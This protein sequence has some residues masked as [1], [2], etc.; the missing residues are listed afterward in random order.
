[1][2]IKELLSKCE[3]AYLDKDFKKLLGLCDEVLKSDPDNQTATSY[4]AISY[5]FL[6]HPERTVEMLEK[7]IQRHPNNY[8][9]KNNL[10]MAYY[11][12]GE[13]EKSLECC[14]EGLEIRDFDWLAENKIKAL[15]KLDRLDEAIEFYESS[16]D[17]IKICKL[18]V[19]AGRY[20][21]ALKYSRCDY[22]KCIDKIKQRDVDAVGEYYLSWIGMI[23]VVNSPDCT[24]RCDDERLKG[25]IEYNIRKLTGILRGKSIVFVHS[26]DT[27]KSELGSLDD[28]EFNAF[29]NRLIEIGYLEEPRKGYVKLAG[30]DGWKCAK[31]YLDE[32]KYAAPPWLVFPSYSAATIGWRMSFGEDYIMNHPHHSKEYAELF[33]M[34]EYWKFAIGERPLK[35][36][37]P[38]GWFWREDGKPKYPKVSKGIKVND[39]I[40]PDDEG[41]FFSDTFCFHSI[42]QSEEI[43]RYLYFE[44]YGSGDDDEDEKTWQSYRYSVLL[45]ASYLKVMQNEDLKQKLLETGDEPLVCVSD[46]G[47][48]LFARALM[49]VRDEIRRVCK[50][51]SL[52][53]WE[54][55][56]YLKYKP[57]W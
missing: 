57:W 53:D 28:N 56:E 49:E 35:P 40:T 11:D 48:N 24:I 36:H 1:M 2:T 26:R 43:S 17:H 44:R 19:E 7:A 20:S 29:V 45:N 10:A 41:E 31:E 47:E 34:P 42:A 55:S 38:I 18:L 13:Y 4:K 33:P 54:Y 5:C 3:D 27:L 30:F 39:F 15:L 37:P 52:I 32:G 25:Y 8:Y 50:N 9:M 6:G 21:E 51:E 12:L 16:Y 22:N 23:E 46:D 14:E